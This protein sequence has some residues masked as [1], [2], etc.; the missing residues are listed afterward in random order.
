MILGWAIMMRKR[1]AMRRRGSRIQSASHEGLDARDVGMP[2]NLLHGVEVELHP[3]QAR[4]VVEV[5]RV[6]RGVGQGMVVAHQLRGRELDE[7]TESRTTTPST[8]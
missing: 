3:G 1:V 2:G 8:A 4:Q 7:S 6:P 5:K